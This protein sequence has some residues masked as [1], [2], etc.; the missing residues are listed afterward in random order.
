MS[1]ATVSIGM[2]RNE[3]DWSQFDGD[4]AKARKHEGLV[5]QA[6]YVNGDKCDV[7]G[8]PR[9]AVA[10]VGGVVREGPRWVGQSGRSQDGWGRTAHP[11][12]IS[13][14]V[15]LMQMC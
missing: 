7:T 1:G 10:K 11:Q 2:Y 3:T 12:L 4:V 8:K 5:H 13:A 9:Q 14:H 6:D 15:V